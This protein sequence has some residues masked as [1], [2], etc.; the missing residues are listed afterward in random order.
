[1]IIKIQIDINLIVP[2]IGNA[3]DNP[4][5][6]FP[7]YDPHFA[8]SK[9][10]PTPWSIMGTPYFSGYLHSFYPRPLPLMTIFVIIIAITKVTTITLLTY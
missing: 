4:R 5:T 2:F 8:T 7:P 9:N 1:V 6:Y 10:I 3:F